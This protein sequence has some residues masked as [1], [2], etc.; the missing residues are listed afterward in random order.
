LKISKLENDLREAKELLKK[1]QPKPVP[2]ESK[3][4]E[5]AKVP[6]LQPVLP[7]QTIKDDSS[8]YFGASKTLRSPAHRNMVIKF[9]RD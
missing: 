4:K 8:K 2:E 6:I 7:V 1:P 3:T 5:F 9:V